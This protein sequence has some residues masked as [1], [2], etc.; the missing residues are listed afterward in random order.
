[1]GAPDRDALDI[2][3]GAEGEAAERFQ[4]GTSPDR[5]KA[6]RAALH[7]PDTCISLVL[8]NPL[9][10]LLLQRIPHIRIQQRSARINNGWAPYFDTARARKNRNLQE[11][12]LL[13]CNALET[14]AVRP[15]CR[16]GRAG[17]SWVHGL[18]F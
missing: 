11:P 6:A 7:H 1:M 9:P 17:K 3:L 18:R 15:G 10:P 12:S 16:F 2:L 4:A 8:Y 14:R 5:E 13:Q